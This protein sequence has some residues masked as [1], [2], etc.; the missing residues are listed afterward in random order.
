M[1]AEDAKK[2]LS[3]TD[4]GGLKINIEWSKRSGKYSGGGSYGGGRISGGM[5]RGV[6]RRQFS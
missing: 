1:D 4:F 3:H 6:A 5:K 2:D